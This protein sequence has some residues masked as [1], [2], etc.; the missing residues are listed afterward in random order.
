METNLKLVH[1]VNINLTFIKRAAFIFHRI[2]RDHVI[3]TCA[4]ICKAKMNKSVR[5]VLYGTYTFMANI[6]NNIA[7][8]IRRFVQEICKDYREKHSSSKLSL[9]AFSLFSMSPIP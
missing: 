2:S 4:T 3:I 6:H 9:M 7:R 1:I 5:E 8:I